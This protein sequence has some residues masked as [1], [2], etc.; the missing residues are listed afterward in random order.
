MFLKTKR[1]GIFAVVLKKEPITHEVNRHSPTLHTAQAD[2]TC[3][4]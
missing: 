1:Q 3:Q 2:I 4:E